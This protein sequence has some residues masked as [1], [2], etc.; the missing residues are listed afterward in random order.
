MS[1]M[2]LIRLANRTGWQSI[3]VVG[4]DQIAFPAKQEFQK[5][6]QVVEGIKKRT[7]L[8]EHVKAKNSKWHIEGE[9]TVFELAS[10]TYHFH[11]FPGQQICHPMY[12]LVSYQVIDHRY[13]D[14]FQS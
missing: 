5:Q 12:P 2:L 8:K 7:F 14:S 6:A 1:G 3:Q 11:T 10:D 13:V 9:R 4:D